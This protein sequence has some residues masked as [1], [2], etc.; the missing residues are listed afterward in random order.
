MLRHGLSSRH[1][2]LLYVTE[3]NDREPRSIQGAIEV[4]YANAYPYG[5]VSGQRKF[6][7]TSPVKSGA[8]MHL[9]EMASRPSLGGR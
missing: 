3:F 4:G 7:V 1:W 8:G 6:M 9:S 5:R 2:A